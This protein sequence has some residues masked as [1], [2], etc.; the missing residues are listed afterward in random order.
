MCLM[1][2]AAF[3]IVAPA[4]GADKPPN[5]SGKWTLNKDKSEFVRGTPD[6]LT[7]AIADDGKRFAWCRR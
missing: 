4:L 1:A 3:V 6:S 2:V 7:A 5:L